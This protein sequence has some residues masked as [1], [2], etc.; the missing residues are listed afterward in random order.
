MKWL[1]IALTIL[2][3]SVL[4]SGCAFFYTWP[5]GV[6]YEASQAITKNDFKRFQKAMWPWARPQVDQKK[7]TL[8][9]TVLG[10]LAYYKFPVEVT[11]PKMFRTDYYDWG[12]VEGYHNEVIVTFRD[13]TKFTI[14]DIFIYCHITDGGSDPYDPR[15]RQEF[16]DCRIE[17]LMMP[18]NS[19]TARFR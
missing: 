9:R 19:F 7:F 6:L 10:A 12:Y 11:D 14:L 3:T 1:R 5:K 8:I 17:D 16:S 15:E 13:G 2:L 18:V 4:F